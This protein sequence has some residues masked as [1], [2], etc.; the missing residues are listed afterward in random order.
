MPN[1]GAEEKELRVRF[2]TAISFASASWAAVKMRTPP[3]TP[4]G[5]IVE[6]ASEWQRKLAPKRRSHRVEGRPQRKLA[7]MKRPMA[8]WP[9]FR[10][11][12]I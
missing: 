6:G 2:S 4:A 11:R 5:R 8:E 1:G 9:K 10:A 7:P 12:A 3:R